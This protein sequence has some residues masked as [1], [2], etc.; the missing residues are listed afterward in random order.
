MRQIQ[1]ILIT[2]AGI[3]LVIVPAM[4][5][6]SLQLK[7]GNFV[8][9]RYLGGT[10]RA[11]QFEVNGKIRL[12][13]VDEIL[14][15]SFAAAS[16]DGG[17]PSN[18]VDPKANSDTLSGRAGQNALDC[19]LLFGIGRG[20]RFFPVSKLPGSNDSTA[21]GPNC[22]RDG[23]WDLRERAAQQWR[24]IPTRRR[25]FVK[26]P[27]DPCASCPCGSLF[28]LTNE[29]AS[30]FRAVSVTLR[31]API[32]FR[33]RGS[34]S[35]LSFPCTHAHREPKS[36]CALLV[37]CVRYRTFKETSGCRRRSPKSTSAR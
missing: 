26:F 24:R 31:R 10:D 6:D 25:E 5:A 22:R 20:R 36:S 9:G 32:P 2:M 33:F 23:Q 8:Q 35:T 29:R 3:L 15:I 12:Y 37:A 21:V 19:A 28:W 1:A 30:A 27:R 11:V 17:L 4:R 13:G 7:S 34:E 18:N 14:S 16:A